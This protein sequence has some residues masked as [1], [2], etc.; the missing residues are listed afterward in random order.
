[1]FLR[2]K[3]FYQNKIQLMFINKRLLRRFL[4]LGRG[5]LFYFCRKSSKLNKT[6]FT[7]KSLFFT[8]EY[9]YIVYVIYLN[10]SPL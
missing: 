1:M 10:H 7:K 8:N 4:F 2:K 9:T 3:G 6:K 5:H